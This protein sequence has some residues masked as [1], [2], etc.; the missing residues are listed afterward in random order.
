MSGMPR[1]GSTTGITP[2]Y[3]VASGPT[4]GTDWCV[5]ADPPPGCLAPGHVVLCVEG[6][7]TP[8]AEAQRAAESAWALLR[9]WHQQRS[10][11]P[12]GDELG[13]SAP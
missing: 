12:A 4:A 11:G 13:S 6:T 5:I 10:A 9:R 3:H 7:Q 8:H 1:S 2:T